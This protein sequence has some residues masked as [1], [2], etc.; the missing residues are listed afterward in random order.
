MTTFCY[1]KLYKKEFT[2]QC[3]SIVITATVHC[4]STKQTKIGLAVSKALGIYSVL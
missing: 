3:W 4:N 1:G 2:M